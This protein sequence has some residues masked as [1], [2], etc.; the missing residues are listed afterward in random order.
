MSVLVSVAQFREWSGA[1]TPASVSDSLVQMSL[2]EAENALLTEA[3]TTIDTVLS[4]P[5]ATAISKGDTMR[6]AS[7]LLA[8]RNSPE[9]IAG[10][11]EAGL[12]IVPSRDPDSA[13]SVR[14]IKAILMIPEAVA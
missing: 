14:Q 7:R 11:G 5:A 1:N 13:A 4:S 9:A 10:A 6:R 8:R 12:I 2:D 3:G